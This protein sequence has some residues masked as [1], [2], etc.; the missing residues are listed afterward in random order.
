MQQYAAAFRDNAVDAAILLELPA[1]D[2]KDLD[3]SIVGH[4]R[5]LLAAI[6]A[7]RS[8]VGPVPETAAPAVTAERPQLTVMVCDLVRSTELSARRDPEDLHEVRLQTT[9]IRLSGCAPAI[10]PGAIGARQSKLHSNSETSSQTPA[11]YCDEGTE[12]LLWESAATRR[13]LAICD[14]DRSAPPEARPFGV[15]VRP[16]STIASRPWRSSRPGRGIP[17]VG[18]ANSPPSMQKLSLTVRRSKRRRP[19]RPG[20]SIVFVNGRPVRREG[21][22]MEELSRPPAA[23]P[24]DAG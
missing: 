17:A 19:R 14:K 3:V 9:I 8:N 4:R 1:D 2:L 23:P 10:A 22:P 6:A 21:E 15:S 5:K 20:S 11:P 12:R 16:P 18:Y 13:R 7:L 24:E